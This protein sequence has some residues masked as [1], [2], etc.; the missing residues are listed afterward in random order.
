MQEP[1]TR[2]KKDLR[3]LRITEY[4]YI[5]IYIYICNAGTADQ[6]KKDLRSLRIT[7]S[8]EHRITLV[9]AGVCDYIYM[10]HNV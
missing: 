2:R 5:Y 1:R 3:S 10:I 8:L 7:K 4:I 9:H 6:K